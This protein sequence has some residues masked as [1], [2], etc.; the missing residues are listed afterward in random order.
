VLAIA[1]AAADMSSRHR[2]LDAPAARHRAGTHT[3]INFLDEA[4]VGVTPQLDS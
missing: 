4:R 3:Y 2:Q 1:P